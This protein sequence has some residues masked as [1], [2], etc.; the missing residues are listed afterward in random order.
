[1]NTPIPMEHARRWCCPFQLSNALHFWVSLKLHST[2]QT[3]ILERRFYGFAKASQLAFPMTSMR[4]ELNALMII[5]LYPFERLGFITSIDYYS[6]LIST[7]RI[8]SNISSFYQAS[9]HHHSIRLCAPLIFQFFQFS[10][11]YPSK[12]LSCS[13]FFS[14]PPGI[15]PLALSLPEPPCKTPPLCKSQNTLLY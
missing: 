9:S 13:P 6:F 10:F 12:P 2:V 14:I 8:R 1:M 15:H 5:Q 3:G 11:M 7:W 4:C